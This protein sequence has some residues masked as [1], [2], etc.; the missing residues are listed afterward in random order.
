MS[1]S[2]EPPHTSK[3]AAGFKRPAGKPRKCLSSRGLFLDAKPP[4]HCGGNDGARSG[5]ERGSAPHVIP[6]RKDILPLS[7]AC[8]IMLSMQH[9]AWQGMEVDES[10]S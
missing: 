5:A 3:A 8:A 4:V 10:H 9:S 2:T 7:P 1:N 6:R